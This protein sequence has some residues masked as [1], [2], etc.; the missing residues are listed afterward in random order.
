MDENEYHSGASTKGSSFQ[1]TSP[2]EIF[3]IATKPF[4]FF[5][6][7]NLT[8]TFGVHLLTSSPSITRDFGNDVSDRDREGPDRGHGLFEERTSPSFCSILLVLFSPTVQ[9]GWVESSTVC[10]LDIPSVG[11]SDLRETR[12]LVRSSSD[13]DTV[14]ILRSETGGYY[15]RQ[16][17]QRD[18]PRSLVAAVEP[19]GGPGVALWL[20][21]VY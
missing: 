20:V 8:P 15:T 21:N 2:S 5:L 10:N 17:L 4:P 13:G 14:D 6:S 9:V 18:H 3:D 19:R 1:T 11:L 16:S 7:K 12:A